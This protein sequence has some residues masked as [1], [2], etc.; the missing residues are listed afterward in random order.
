MKSFFVCILLVCVCA[1]ASES[2]FGNSGS[3][4]SLILGE[5]SS[6]RG[7]ASLTP[8]YAEMAVDSS[9]VIGPGD[10]LDLML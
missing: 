6:M 8:M 9:Y 1:F 3:A 5:G 2:M 10:F 4:R 7:E